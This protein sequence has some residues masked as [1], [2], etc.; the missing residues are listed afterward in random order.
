MESDADRMEF[1]QEL[2]EVAL[3]D[4]GDGGWGYES[5]KAWDAIHRCLTD[6][7]L[8]TGQGPL[9]FAIL[10]GKSLYAGDD[11][12]IRL[13]TP[14][15]AEE[16]AAAARRMDRAAL[17]HRYDA[18]QADYPR[19]LLGP[20]DFEYVW[21]HFEGLPAFLERASGAGRWVVFTADQ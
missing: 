20:D 11:Y 8:N 14:Q 21:E 12:I 13:I 18:M 10:G 16:A 3:E 5:G 7:S 15:Q 4:N 6:G 17:K 2:E 19:E 9:S 1:I